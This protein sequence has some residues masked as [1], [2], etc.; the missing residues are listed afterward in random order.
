M[1]RKG[2]HSGYASLVAAAFDCRRPLFFRNGI[3]LFL[4]RVYWFGCPFIQCI[5]T[6][7][8]LAPFNA[9]VASQFLTRIY[10]HAP[11]PLNEPC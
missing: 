7:S 4:G 9:V 5:I 2:S 10:Y 3:C 11:V 6:G 8:G 1:M